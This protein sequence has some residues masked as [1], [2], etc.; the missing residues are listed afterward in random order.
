MPPAKPRFKTKTSAMSARLENSLRERLDRINARHGVNDSLI[1]A[2]LLPAFCDA[3]EEAD[4]VR[5]PAMILLAEKLYAVGEA[6]NVDELKSGKAPPKPPDKSQRF[7]G[8]GPRRA[9]S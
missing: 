9:V 4:A 2:N 1:L 3:V 7:R 8:D 5:W 6:A